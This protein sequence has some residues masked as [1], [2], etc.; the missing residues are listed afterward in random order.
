M[1][2]ISDLIPVAEKISDLIRE[3]YFKKGRIRIVVDRTD[4]E[5][6]RRQTIIEGIWDRWTDHPPGLCL[7]DVETYD[8]IQTARR[9]FVKQ[10]AAGADFSEIGERYLWLQYLL[11]YEAEPR[12]NH[13]NYAG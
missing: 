1:V 13:R 3:G 9:K 5:L 4:T 11:F 12:F 10:G 8:W 6:E 7:K 2:S